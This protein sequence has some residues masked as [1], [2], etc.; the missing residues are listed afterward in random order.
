MSRRRTRKRTGRTELSAA[1]KYEASQFRAL[2]SCF[3]FSPAIIHPTLDT[4]GQLSDLQ[5]RQNALGEGTGMPSTPTVA[6]VELHPTF[7]GFRLQNY[8]LVVET[9]DLSK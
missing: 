5:C 9:R 6:R 3:L 4:E 2:H 8:P 1:S 7:S